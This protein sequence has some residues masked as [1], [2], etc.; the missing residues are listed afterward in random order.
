MLESENWQAGTEFLIHATN[1]LICPEESL[2]S[3]Q[4]DL[5]AAF[6]RIKEETCEL[7]IQRIIT[8]QLGWLVIFSEMDRKTLECFIERKEQKD[9]LQILRSKLR[10]QEQEIERKEEEERQSQLERKK[11]EEQEKEKDVREN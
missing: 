2:E 4:R 5:E 3:L 8:H 7:T 1:K 9:E 6:S 11:R 10:A